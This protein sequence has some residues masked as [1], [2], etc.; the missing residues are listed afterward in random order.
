MKLAVIGTGKIVKEALFA[1]SCV[2]EISMTAIFGRPHSRQKA[3]DLAAQYGIAA[4]YT[5]YA[6]LLSEADIDAVYIGLV[7]SAHY[8]YARQA[9][10]AGRHV[11]LEKPFTS[12]AREA[13]DLVSLAKEKGLFIL[14]AI[15]TVHG[16]VFGKLR[17]M[18]PRIGTLKIHQGN[19][20]QY[21]SRYG[22]YLKGN[23]S[24][25]FDPA[26]SGGAL[27]DINLYNIY[28]AAALYGKPEQAFYFP[29]R[30]FNGAD[31]SGTAVLSYPGFQAVLTG[32]KD[33]DSPCQTVIQG[34][35]GWIRIPGKPNNPE[36]LEMEY[37]DEDGPDVLSS[38]G[39][40]DR[41]M[42]R[43]QYS[44]PPCPHRMVPEF[45]AFARIIDTEDREAAERCSQA[46]LCVMEILEETRKSAGIRFG[47]DD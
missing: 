15:T 6:A 35:K 20:S 8:T 21:S 14:E 37:W 41:A 18:L 22:D 40:R 24:P 34:E 28:M 17:E 45:E 2:K 23:V 13:E 5:D 39:G 30:G 1:A 38:S 36:G 33:S 47:V 25:V 27:Y 3:A 7:N 42:I 16:P 12:T 43:D 32:A 9:L 11:I 10:E 44:A 4:V 26:L 31:T 19:F 29:N 46:S